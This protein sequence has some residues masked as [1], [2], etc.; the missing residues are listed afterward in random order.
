[1]RVIAVVFGAPTSKERNAQVTKMLDYAF[2]QYK[3]HPLFERNHVMGSVK[4]QKGAEKT[5]EAVTSEPISLL[6]K[7]GENIDD[8]QQTV[9]VNKDLK[10]PIKKGDPIGMLKI[11][12][13]GEALVESPLLAKENVEE[14]SWWKLFNRSFGMFTK[15]E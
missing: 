9:N 14:A 11:E 4:V 6:T 3:T 1:M 10:A 12:K 2:N 8:I 13:N 7:K 5:V 15:T